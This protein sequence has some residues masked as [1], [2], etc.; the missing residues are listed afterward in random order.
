MH[1]IDRR[2]ADEWLVRKPRLLIVAV[3]AAE[4]STVSSPARS[5]AV[6]TDEPAPNAAPATIRLRR[7][8][9]VGKPATRRA[10]E[11]VIVT[12][13]RTPS[14]RYAMRFDSHSATVGHDRKSTNF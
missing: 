13:A 6:A 7:D 12:H 14:S 1:G 9:G 4:I 5:C 10:C 3:S 11:D 8:I 2:A